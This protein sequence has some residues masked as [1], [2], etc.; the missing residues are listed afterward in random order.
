MQLFCC[1]VC[2]EEEQADSED[3]EG[4]D[5]DELASASDK[6]SSRVTQQKVCYVVFTSCLPGS[7]LH[8]MCQ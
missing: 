4:S 3:E 8:M 7:H 6:V 2:A 1:F 5:D